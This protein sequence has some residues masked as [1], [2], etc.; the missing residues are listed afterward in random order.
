MFFGYLWITAWIDY[1]S[2]FVVIMSASTYYFNHSEAKPD[3]SASADIGYS[4]KVAYFCHMG[5]L[6]YGAILIAFIRF[7]KYVFY[8]MAKKLQKWQGDNCCVKCFVA[9]GTCILN[10]IERICDYINEAAYCYQAVSGDSFISSAWNGFLL[11]LKHGL[12]FGF[13]KFMAKIFILKG[14]VSIVVASCFTLYWLMM[15]RKDLEE[16]N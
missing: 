3:E 14:K 4:F 2:R 11:N 1:T 12:K 6:A 7:I 15:A 16:V 5:S 10:C 9:C 13:A 8:N